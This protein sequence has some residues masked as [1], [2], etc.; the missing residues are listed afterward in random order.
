MS[1]TLDIIPYNNE[2]VEK[3]RFLRKNS[4]PGEIEFWKGLKGKQMLG[5]DFDRQKPIQNFIIDFYCKKLKLAIEIDGISHDYKIDYDTIREMELHQF[6]INILRFNEEDAKHNT[7]QCLNEIKY[8]I[9]NHPP[10][11][12]PMEGNSIVKGETYRYY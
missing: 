8:W 1:S 5:F 2:L 10:L 4:T 3:A 6:G 11:T 9:N 12:P 7:E